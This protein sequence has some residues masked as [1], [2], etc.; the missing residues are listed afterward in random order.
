MASNQVLV[1][2]VWS[3]VALIAV[4]IVVGLFGLFEI[5]HEV[6]LKDGTVLVGEA[7]QRDDKILPFKLVSGRDERI[8]LDQ[9]ERESRFRVDVDLS[10]GLDLKGGTTLRYRVDPPSDPTADAHQALDRAVDTFRD[11]LDRLGVKEIGIAPAY[12]TSQVIIEL[13]GVTMDEAESYQKVIESLGHLEFRIMLGE[14]SR[15][16]SY[17]AERER[18]QKFLD[19][20]PGWNV[21]SIDLRQFDIKGANGVVHRWYPYSQRAIEEGSASPSF[22]FGLLTIDPAQEITGRDLENVYADTDRRGMNAIGFRLKPDRADAFGEFTGSH[23]D[24]S[25]AIVLDGEINSAANLNSRIDH[26]GIIEGGSRGFPEDAVK[27]YIATLRSG[28]LEVKP[29]LQSKATI[30]PTLGEA[31]ISRGLLSG[32]IAGLLVIVFIMAYYPGVAGI[33]TLVTLFL[34][35]FLLIG[36]LG[37]LGATLTLPG[38]AGIILTLG[39]AV[40]QNILI[41][42]RVRE[43]RAKGKTLFQSV[44][45]GFERAV[46]TIFDSQATTFLTGA[47]LYA[48]GTGP[49]KGFAVT[50]MLGIITSMFAAVLGSKVLFSIG[51]D[52]GWF[53]SIKFRDPLGKMAVPYLNFGRSALIG[54]TLVTLLGLGV[55]AITY[56]DLRGIDFAGGMQAHVRFK[57]AADTGDVEKLVASRFENAQVVSMRT[58]EGSEGRDFLI[59][60]RASADE[61]S[62]TTFLNDLKAA[63]GDRLVAEG[64]A[65]VVVTPSADG[66]SSNAEFTLAFTGPVAQDVIES[67]LK[68]RMSVET[69]TAEGGASPS[70][71]YRVKSSFALL[72]DPA[73]IEAEIVSSL[74]NLPNG[75]ALANPIQNSLFINASVGK[76]LRNSAIKAMILAIIGMLIYIRVRFHDVT[77][78]YAATIAVAHDALMTLGLVAIFAKL[79]L[80]NMELDLT[81]VGSFLTLVGYSINDKIVIFD[82]I[83]ENLPKVDKPFREIIDLSI[84]QT[85]SRTLLTGGSV[86]FA[87]L[88]ML[89]MN[90]GYDSV[91]EGFA[92]VMLAG[93][94]IG[95]YSSIFIACPL[96]LAYFTRSQK[97]LASTGGQRPAQKPQPANS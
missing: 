59:K 63:L 86:I 19:A 65:N 75:I 64:L 96:L 57:D 92:F 34:G 70:A 20:N 55:F 44:K 35:V 87:L 2:N 88:V 10:L 17:E 74:A 49:I 67:R 91:I 47:I 76:E 3:K 85:M 32:G 28:S 33:V 66:T 39:M 68:S 97:L 54:S 73:R 82:R 9:I 25:M 58:A 71:N 21:K 60:V 29:E 89:I 5:R 8:P 18:V 22:P 15:E 79:G 61:S 6:V 12:E 80:I 77:W 46:I 84:N 24:Q 95:T 27:R 31:A 93:V 1:P 78:G 38:I 11:R 16:V 40:D 51:L 37:F 23:I 72:R 7:G 4:T 56:S 36:G 41:L 26:Q 94:I 90:V 81:M 13:P 14:R 48:L 83:R 69:V 62:G 30:G 42:E 43:E 50:L 53:D 45:N 52:R